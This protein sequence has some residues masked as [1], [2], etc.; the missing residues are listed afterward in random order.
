MNRQ[1]KAVLMSALVYPG[2]GHLM[3]KKYPVGLAFVGVF[4]IFLYLVVGNIMEKTNLIVEQITNG[5]IPLTVAAIS[6]AVSGI[7]SGTEGEA[8]N[9]N[10]YVMIFVWAVAIFDVYRVSRVTATATA[11]TDEKEPKG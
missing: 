10:I 1:L 5:Q 3:L 4:S 8:L 6:E 11:A 9:F 2:A 7:T